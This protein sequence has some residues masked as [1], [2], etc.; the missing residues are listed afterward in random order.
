MSPKFIALF[1][2]IAVATAGVLNT[3]HN[4]THLTI[5]YNDVKPVLPSFNKTEFKIIKQTNNSVCIASPEGSN[6][7]ATNKGCFWCINNCAAMGYQY[8]CCDV[9]HCCCYQEP[10]WCYGCNSRNDCICVIHK[11]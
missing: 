11:C 1:S 2:L 4:D 6:P 9:S 5:D 10:A 3:P 7:C 8:S